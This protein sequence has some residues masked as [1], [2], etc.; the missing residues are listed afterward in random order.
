MAFL[1][2]VVMTGAPRD[3]ETVRKALRELSCRADSGDAKALYDLACL[4]D[5]GYDTISK[6]SAMSTVLY[7][8]SAQLGYAPAR[9]YLGFRYYNGEGGVRRDVDS[10]LF[11]IERAAESGDPKGAANLGWLLVEGKDV[12]RDYS[13]AAYWLEKAAGAGLPV[14]MTQLADLYREGLG[15]GKDTVRAV[16]LYTEAIERGFREAEP[17]LL[18]MMLD[19]W[20][21]LPADSAIKTGRYYYLHRAPVIGVNIFDYLAAKGDPEAQAL[22]GDAYSR[23]QGVD[24]SHEK[25]LEYYLR[26]AT[27]GNPSAQFVIGELLDIFPDALDEDSCAVILESAGISSSDAAFPLFWYGKAASCGITDAA[28]ASRRLL[29]G[30]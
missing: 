6:D 18:D 2:F 19:R 16:W 27:G 20:K 17:L 13:H 7:R 14:G 28:S 29:Y 4:Y 26:A 5:V 22:M 15:V 10:A 12:V 23:A 8:R 25:S 30:D 9:N 21:A 11:W 3:R 24:Y 1:A